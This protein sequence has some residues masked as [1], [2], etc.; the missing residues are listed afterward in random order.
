[1]KLSR[2]FSLEEFTRSSR[3][4]LKQIDNTPTQ[5]HIDNLKKLCEA[6]LQPVRDTLGLPLT[7]TSG[8]RSSALNTAVRGSESSQHCK[9]EASDFVVQGKTPKEVCELVLE[10]K[11]DFDQMIDEGTWVHI[12]YKAQGKNRNE[13]LKATFDS[14]G[15][16][17]Y[18][19]VQSAKVATPKATTTKPKA[20]KTDQGGNDDLSCVKP[21]A[22]PLEED[23]S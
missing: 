12:S 19:K 7:V 6:I 21:S 15:K 14:N 17:S 1:M 13:Y 22:K 16:A 2:N 10:L 20:R 8:Y 23:I 18:T 9:G 11:L 4:K 3:A 5:D